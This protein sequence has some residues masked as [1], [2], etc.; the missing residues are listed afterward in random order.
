[1]SVKVSALVWQ[2]P[3]SIPYLG[4]DKEGKP[5][6]SVFDI[7]PAY[8]LVLLG[9]ADHANDEGSCWPS[10]QSLAEKCAVSIR[11]VNGCL[12]GASAAGLL[13][14]KH[15]KGLRGLRTVS[16]YVLDVPILE[17]HRRRASATAAT[18]DLRSATQSSVFE[19]RNSGRSATHGLR[20]E[21]S[22]RQTSKETTREHP[23]ASVAGVRIPANVRSALKGWGEDITAKIRRRLDHAAHKHGARVIHM[24]FNRL[25]EQLAGGYPIKKPV[26]FMN[27]FIEEQ[28]RIAGRSRERA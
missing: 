15:R 19:L 5:L 26:G 8:R 11:T 3:P 9:L 7:T 6:R 28:E 24:I 16:R 17:K 12:T 4:R 22:V 10:Q 2:L 25:D 27:S 23:P 18:Q 13:H 14:I 21:T 1:M 20:R